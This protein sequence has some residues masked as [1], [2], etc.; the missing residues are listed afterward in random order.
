MANDDNIAARGGLL[1]VNFP[2]GNFRRT[3]YKLTTS[4]TAAVFI[5]QPMDL[6]TNGQVAPA[7]VTVRSNLVG[8]VVGFT[9]TAKAGIPSDMTSLTQGGFLPANK[10]AYCI[11]ADDPDQLF[12]IQE[13]T[14]GSAL[15]QSAVGNSVGIIP[16][17]SSGSTVTGYS[18]FEADRSTVVAT[19]SGSLGIVGLVDLMNSDGTANDFG[20]YAKL[21]VRINWH[22]Y[23]GRAD[24]IV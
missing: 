4:A 23:S 22:R 16:R 3:L 9:D 7:G 21:L 12:Q 2:Y 13:D 19:D 11:I 1:P 24:N 5:G 8:P 15:T 20:D 14:G 10:D 17:T 6:D 18:T